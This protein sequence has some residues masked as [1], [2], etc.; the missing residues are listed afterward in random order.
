MREALIASKDR[1]PPPYTFHQALAVKV[2]PLLST[3]PLGTKP[4]A[5]EPSGAGCTH[6][7]VS[8][9]ALCIGCPVADSM[10]SFIWPFSPFLEHS[11]WEGSFP[12]CPS[13]WEEAGSALTF[14]HGPSLPIFLWFA[15]EPLQ[16]V[17]TPELHEGG[18]HL[19]GSPPHSNTCRVPGTGGQHSSTIHHSRKEDNTQ[20]STQGDASS[21]HPQCYPDMKRNAINPDGHE[22]KNWW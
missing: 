6:I 16:N 14:A 4:P 21:V 11:Y 10:P 3:V 20:L 2:P 1:S 15:A 17:C 5:G 18:G 9:C 7:T 12:D 19:S 8:P 13:C 22:R